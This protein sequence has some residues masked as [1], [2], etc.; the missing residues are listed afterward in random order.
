[1]ASLS[2]EYD[3]HIDLATIEGVRYAGG[4]FRGL[5]ILPVGTVV[6]I[7]KREDGVITVTRLY[8]YESRAEAK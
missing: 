5:A 1:M 4:F 8:E 2:F 3:P 7:D 6:R